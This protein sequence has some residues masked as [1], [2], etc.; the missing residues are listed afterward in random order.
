MGHSLKCDWFMNV[1]ISERDDDVGGDDEDV[2][3]DDYQ[4][5]ACPAVEPALLLNKS[6]LSSL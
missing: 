2:D 3:K 4:G 5:I 1:T 6:L